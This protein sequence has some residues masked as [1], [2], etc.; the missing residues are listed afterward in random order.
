MSE[1]TFDFPGLEIGVAEYEEGPTGCTVFHFSRQAVQ[2]VHDV[3][4]GSPGV[5]GT[6][7]LAHAICLAGGSAYGLEA[8]AGVQAELLERRGF[9]TAWEDIA[10]VHGAIIYDFGRRE[11]A[12]YPDKELGRQ[13]LRNARE[14]VFPC[15]AR[16]AGRSATVGKTFGHERGE[17]SGQGG[18]FR[19]I[20]DTRV[21][22]FT[23]VNAFGAVI[24]R[25]GNVVRGYYD[26]ETG[27]RTAL[28]D[29]LEERLAAP[30]PG[31]TT[32]TIV[33]TNQILDARAHRQLAAQVHASMARAIQPFHALVDGDVLFA[34]TT[35]EVDNSALDPMTLAVVAS[36]L[37]WDAV[38][39]AVR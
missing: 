16:G 33:V 11:N 5:F 29:A 2:V 3:R 25:S 7:G 28:A 23:V 27:T 8:A 4:G 17:Q 35:A 1:L 9:S 36:E 14:G 24:D 38:L 13:A 31:H 18:A 15:G 37:A 32:L 21:A 10:I 12:V 34:V 30:P 19:A 39:S 6:A 22:V 20:G 26:A